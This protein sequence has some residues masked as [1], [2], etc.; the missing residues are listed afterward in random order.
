MAL[1]TSY[2]KPRWSSRP[3]LQLTPNA[4]LYGFCKLQL[5]SKLL[6][7]TA[8]KDWKIEGSYFSWCFRTFESPP[9]PYPS[10]QNLSPILLGEREICSFNVK[11]CKLHIIAYDIK[12]PEDCAFTETLNLPNRG[13]KIVHMK[14]LFPKP[15]F[16]DKVP[17]CFYWKSLLSLPHRLRARS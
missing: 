16:S 6:T 5:Y 11:L 17:S 2:E 12:K 10:P 8:P 4:K 7:N 13:W 14:N 3:H 9:L 15:T 1:S